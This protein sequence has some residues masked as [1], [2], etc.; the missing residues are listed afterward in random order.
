MSFCQFR[1]YKV[2]GAS[3]VRS[4]ARCVVAIDRVATGTI[5]I[6]N[7][8]TTDRSRDRI[9]GRRGGRRRSGISVRPVGQSIELI[10][11]QA[12]ILVVAL[13][14]AD[15]QVALA[16]ELRG[17]TVRIVAAENM[18][19]GTVVIV[20]SLTA[21]R[22][23]RRVWSRSGVRRRSGIGIRPVG[24]SVEFIG[25]QADILVAVLD[26]ADDLIAQPSEGLRSTDIITSQ[27]IDLRTSE[28]WAIRSSARSRATTRISA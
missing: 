17:R 18:T 8:L 4:T 20:D 24:Q 19:A 13:D 5:G 28:G 26:L 2:A 3:Q 7:S 12:D 1:G 14:L 9:R 10:D 25:G 23:R 6:V 16:A 27:T 22:S 21:D 15:N 11:A